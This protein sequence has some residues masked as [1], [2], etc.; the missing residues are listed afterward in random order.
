MCDD[1]KC[2]ICGRKMIWFVQ[3]L[4]CPVCDWVQIWE[5]TYDYDVQ[6]GRIENE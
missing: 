3:T 2:P 6:M 1:L 5:L 4:L